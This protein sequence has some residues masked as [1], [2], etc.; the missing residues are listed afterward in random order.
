MVNRALSFA[1]SEPKGPVYL[2]GAREVMEEEL[3]PYHLDQS[4][5]RPVEPPALPPSGVKTIAEAL[6]TAEGPLVI[7]GYSG[8]NHR[9]V[10]ELVALAD[11]VPGLR[12]LDTGGSDMCFPANHPAWLGLRYG[13]D[14]SIKTA[15]VI[16]VLDCDVPWINT[17]CHPKDGARIYH[18]DVDPL[19]QQMPVFYINALR[20]YKA[21]SET[22]LIQLR[23]YISTNHGA[24]V[25]QLKEQ[26]WNKLVQSHQQRLQTI[27]ELA[28][29]DEDGHFGPSYLISQVRKACPEDTIWAIEAVTCTAFV[30]DQLQ[31]T[32]PGSWINCGGG[33]LGWSGGGVCLHLS[34]VPSLLPTTTPSDS[35]PTGPRHQTSLRHRVRRPRQRPLRRANRRRRDVPLLGPLLRL[36]DLPALRPPHPDHRAQQPRLERAP[37]LAAPRASGRRGEQGQQRGAEHQ[38]CAQPGL[39]G[40][41]GRGERWEVLGWERED[42]GG[43]AGEVGGGGECGKGWEERGVGCMD[44]GG[45]GRLWGW[46]GGDCWV[47]GLFQRLA[48]GQATGAEVMRSVA[49]ATCKGFAT[50]SH[51]LSCASD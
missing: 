27:R 42:S 43:V 40:H 38:L 17:Q 13:I 31:A 49:L 46:E 25:Q 30:A 11:T 19:K 22:A 29:P 5:W 4:F 16:L 48:E 33:G 26:R 18:I 51:A 44:Y 45:A 35:L 47:S 20:R 3:E 50:G 6:V 14:D 41:C 8:R 21:D 10:H 28:V 1:T 12:V 9:A 34:P 37:P 7:A 2:I 24:E 39:R 36:L 23:A 15:D 32:L